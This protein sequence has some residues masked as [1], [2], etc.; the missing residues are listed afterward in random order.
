VPLHK[1]YVA[2]LTGLPANLPA[3]LALVLPVTAFYGLMTVL[4]EFPSGL[5]DTARILALVGMLYG[6]LKALSQSRAVS[7]VAYGGLASLS[8]LWWYLV[9]AQA[10]PPQTVVYLS[11]VSLATGG[12][13]L[14]WSM[15]RARYGDMGLRALSG[16][17]EPMPRL[18]V[19]LSLLA[20]AAL[21]LPPFGVFSGF[22][23]MLLTP[24]LAWSG[25]LSVLIIAWLGASWY[26][27][28]LAQGLLF[29]DRRPD[30]RHEDLRDSE[31]ASLAM[32]LV[33]LFALGVLPSRLFDVGPADLQRTV[34]MGVSAW[35][36]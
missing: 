21:G 6:S 5:M 3:F 9:T 34:V 15:M 8:I 27:F 13:L 20:L 35:N 7:V 18:T 26:V 28:D 4:P 24:S 17:A 31:L 10:A 33:L 36:E 2:A 16:L 30:L 19:V 12:L 1:G 22:I 11:A 29:G 23:G 14:A 25:G 32:V